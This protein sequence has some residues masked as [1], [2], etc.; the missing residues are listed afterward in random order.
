MRQPVYFLSHGGP[1]SMLEIESAP[2]QYW[3]AVGKEIKSSKPEGIVI[4]SAHWDS[5]QEGEVDVSFDED[6][7]LIYDF[8]GFPAHYYNV[9]FRSKNPSI[10][11]NMIADTI[12]RSG[13]KTRGKKRGLD[14]GAWVPLKVMFDGATDIPICQVALPSRENPEANIK[15]GKAASS[16]RE[17]NVLIICSGM[18]IHN[19]QVAMS[20]TPFEVDISPFKAFDN[21]L[22]EAITSPQSARETKMKKLM[23]HS[24][25][26]KSHPTGEHLMPIYVALGAAGSD[27]AKLVFNQIQPGLGWAMY[28]FKP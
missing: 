5:D 24:E 6:N 25:F 17:E 9:K 13:F 11:H 23:K 27:N 16:L 15:I 8:Y 28:Y 19:L 4:F 12:H 2:Y 20:D 14:H 10:F 26:R 3:T 18:A 22:Y 7:E 1:S 21:A